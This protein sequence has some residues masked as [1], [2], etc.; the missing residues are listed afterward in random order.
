LK[1]T[2]I[3]HRF[4]G[5]T[6]RVLE[7]GTLVTSLGCHALD[8]FE[9]NIELNLRFMIDLEVVRLAVTSLSASVVDQTSSAS[10]VDQTSSMSCLLHSHFLLIL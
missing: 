4:I 3:Q 6:R 8:A 1:V 9:S 2:V 10:V 7:S 5:A